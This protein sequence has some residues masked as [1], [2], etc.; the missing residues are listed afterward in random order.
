MLSAA[1]VLGLLVAIQRIV[2]AVRTGTWSEE[3]CSPTHT[4]R[5]A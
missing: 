1:L 2:R 3:P 5:K 4:K